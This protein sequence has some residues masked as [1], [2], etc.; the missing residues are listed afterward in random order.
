MPERGPGTRASLEIPRARIAEEDEHFEY[1]KGAMTA[2]EQVDRMFRR[3]RSGCG[4]IAAYAGGA[5]DAR[6]TPAVRTFWWMDY[7][8]GRYYARTGD[9]IIAEPLDGAR[10]VAG[11]RQ[12]LRRAQRHHRGE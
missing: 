3:P 1:R 10:M 12:L 9:P 8:D 11:I 4:E 6:P 5:V 2:T 7:P